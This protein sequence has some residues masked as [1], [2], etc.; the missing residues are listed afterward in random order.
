MSAFAKSCDR[1]LP[2]PPGAALGA[3]G[4]AGPAKDWQ[5]VCRALGS[6][7]GIDRA[8]ARAFLE[9]W[10]R[11]F[12]VRA[13]D[14]GAGGL[15][16]GYFVPELRGALVRG[17]RFQVPLY[18]RP[19][20]LV[21]VD[22]GRF[23]SSLAGRTLAGRM[24]GGALAPY[25]TRREIDAGA[26]GGRARPILWVDSRIDAFF[27]HI[28]G[29]GV[30]SLAGGETVRVG[31]AATNGRPYTAI[32]GTLAERGEIPRD[33]VS[34]QTIRA[35]LSAH[36]DKAGEVMA[37]NDRYVFFRRLPGA[38]V[39][40]AQGVALTP[41]RSVAVDR[42]FL[43][44]GAPLWVDTNDPIDP[45]RPFRRLMVAQDTGGAINGIVRGDIFFGQG[46]LAARRAGLMNQ[47]GRYYILLPRT[48]APP[49]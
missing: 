31:Y 42:R 35:W 29:S 39:L 22:L 5:D 38:A 17:G 46:H 47:R 3:G 44:L 14:G 7:A 48:V 34:M 45:T 19:D 12:A 9:K 20:D 24:E 1:L 13:P 32:G 23:D 30:V 28:Q 49:P 43:P 11:P 6:A 15:F 21:T 26:L 33:R 40:G 25:P 18:G 36:A 8:R 2:L 4:F 16:T 10:F 37:R 41:E 27:L